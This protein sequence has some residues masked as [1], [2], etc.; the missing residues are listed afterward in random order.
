MEIP[1]NI[2]YLGSLLTLFQFWHTEYFTTLKSLECHAGDKAISFKK[3][4]LWLKQSEL[5]E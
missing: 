2:M 5:V 4:S 1:Q 3:Y